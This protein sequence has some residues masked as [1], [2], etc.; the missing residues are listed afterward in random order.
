MFIV[1]G[2]L[3]LL[4]MLVS[5]FKQIKLY[6]N[7]IAKV[8]NEVTQKQTYD[9]KGIVT[10]ESL[11]SELRAAAESDGFTDSERILLLGDD[12]YQKFMQF[13][14]GA[15]YI[16]EFQASRGYNQTYFTLSYYDYSQEMKTIPQREPEQEG[17]TEENAEAEQG[18]NT[19]SE[20]EENTAL[21]VERDISVNAPNTETSSENTS[22]VSNSASNEDE[23]LE[24]PEG[25]E[26]LGESKKGPEDSSESEEEPEDSN[27]LENES[28]NQSNQGIVY[29][30]GENVEA[31]AL[32]LPKKASFMPNE[33]I[34][35]TQ[36]VVKN[37][38]Y[39]WAY[40]NIYQADGSLNVYYVDADLLLRLDNITSG[41]E[42]ISWT[43]E[44]GLKGVVRK[45]S[46]TSQLLAGSMLEETDGTKI[47]NVYFALMDEANKSQDLVVAK[48]DTYMGTIYYV[49]AINNI[50]K[51]SDSL[52]NQTVNQAIYRQLQY[53]SETQYLSSDFRNTLTTIKSNMTPEQ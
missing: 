21:E 18:E 4:S 26:G 30:P 47:C 20:S 40:V 24:E 35:L 43:Q 10:Y 1:I 36:Q 7:E 5:K 8:T 13:D 38:G 49:N 23:E 51:F 27:E 37:S 6:N 19:K 42:G 22:S 46:G 3:I 33:I 34:A 14:D 44:G 15:N 41:E 52:K 25:F 31:G 9:N 48:L 45:T 16:V 12:N 2:I 28:E 32:I 29:T 39:S 50:C 53:L 11:A 17:N